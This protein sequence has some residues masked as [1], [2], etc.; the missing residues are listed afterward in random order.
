MAYC[1]LDKRLIN[2]IDSIPQKK[3]DAKKFDEKVCQIKE[4][5]DKVH[6]K[7][8]NIFVSTIDGYTMS[9]FVDDMNKTTVEDLKIMIQVK[10]KILCRKQTLA[11]VGKQLQNNCLLSDYGIVPQSKLHLVGY[12]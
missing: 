2:L 6:E 1:N 10:S 12:Y 5:M 3:L 7:D 4:M 8:C 9:F 11:F